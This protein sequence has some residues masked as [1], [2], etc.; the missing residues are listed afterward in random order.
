MWH[1]SRHLDR[2][3]KKNT[4]VVIAKAR[5]PILKF[6]DE[7][8]DLKVDISFENDSGLRAIGTFLEW[9]RDYPEAPQLVVIVKQLLAMRGLNEV[10]SGGIGGFTII[11]LVISMFQL[12]PQEQSRSGNSQGRLG[13]LLLNFLDLY[14]NKFNR[15]TTGITMDPPGYFNK[16]T[17]FCAAKINPTGLTIIDPNRAN[18]DISGGS[19]Q[20]E[21]VFK[22]FRG[23]LSMIQHRLDAI[24]K[25]ESDEKSILGCV[26]GGNYSS[27]IQ[28][29]KILRDCADRRQSPVSQSLPIRGSATKPQQ[30]PQ[31]ITAALAPH[32][33]GTYSQRAPV[34]HSVERLPRLHPWELMPRRAPFSATER[35]WMEVYGESNFSQAP[36]YRSPPPPP[37]ARPPPPQVRAQA[38]APRHALPPRPIQHPN[39]PQPANYMRQPEES[40]WRPSSYDNNLIPR[41]K[42]SLHFDSSISR[43][44]RNVEN[45]YSGPRERFQAQARPALQS[46]TVYVRPCDLCMIG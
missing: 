46:Q 9:K 41:S 29:R 25:G 26:L 3:A 11:C 28:Q 19:K 13:E 18:N 40:D 27:F 5:V 38:Q 30:Q 7:R 39:V 31:P 44:E 34:E 37:P 12:M 14:G 21:T 1:L 23:A 16:Q 22:C 4:M 2:I 24:S 32:L 8:T 42:N 45:G 33:M 15:H 43:S 6:V 20:V 10:H 17:D 36:A 35:Y